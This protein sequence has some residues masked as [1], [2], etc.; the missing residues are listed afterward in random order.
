MAKTNYTKVE[1]ALAEGMRK[2]EVN[3]LLKAADKAKED[4]STDVQKPSSA[5]TSP[6]KPEVDAVNLQRLKTV[7]RDLKALQ[8]LGRNPYEELKIN[9]EEIK[10]FI[11]DPSSLTPEEWQKV[12]EIKSK[13]AKYKEEKPQKT[14][15]KG[16][17]DDDPLQEERKKQATKR[18]N[19]KDSWIPLR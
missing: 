10:K 8:K 4:K 17:K 18:F 9:K 3:R 16:E 15:E 14:Q 2:M 11:K 1:E 6:A 7:C 19:V 12:K 13:I 5:P